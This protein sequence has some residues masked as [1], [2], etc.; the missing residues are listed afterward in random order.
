MDFSWTEEQEAGFESSARFASEALN[1]DLP[2]R[3][4]SSTFSTEAWRRCAEHGVFGWTL[5]RAF[6]G[7]DIGLLSPIPRLEGLGYGCRDNGLTLALNAQIWT[8]QVPLLEFGTEAQKA[9]YLP[10][11]CKGT[12]LAADGITEAQSGSDVFSM[13][14]RA[15]RV[16]GG[17]RLTGQKCYIGLAPVADVSLIF[18]ITDPE[19]GSWGVSA[20]LVDSDSAG[21]EASCPQEKMG[22]RTE[23]LGDITLTDCFVPEENRLGP[24]GA[25]AS[26]FNYTMDW[27]RSFIFAS[28]LGAMARQLDECI[29]WA[30]KRRQFG[31]PIGRFQSVANRLA[32]M[33]P[34][35]ET[36][37]MLLYR[38][39]WVKETGG[40]SPMDAAMTKLQ[41]S[42]SFAANSLDAMRVHGARG[43]LGEYGVERD[44]RDALG[45]VIY[46]GTSDIQ[47]NII[48]RSLG[49]V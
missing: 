8:V 32:G 10:A 13:Q 48:A 24:E 38:M 26:I 15:E 18:A 41:V 5:P 1:D 3:D 45:G 44:V 47:R 49:L 36:S 31:E 34:R 17:Y 2:E 39:A 16:D 33:K 42:E 27:E 40:S 12:F 35:L 19:R 25:G 7:T 37:R 29:A 22:L 21:Y 9:R 4:R 20:F 23:P 46:G 14:T 6:G 30:R 43:Y 28:H 11:L